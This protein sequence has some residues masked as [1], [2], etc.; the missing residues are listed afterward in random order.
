MI[1]IKTIHKDNH[2]GQHDYAMIAELDGDFAGQLDYSMY[3]AR[4]AVQGINVLQSKRRQGVGTALLVA[5]QEAYPDQAILF[6]MTTT[7]GNA[8]LDSLEWRVEVNQVVAD[9]AEEIATLTQ[10]LRGYES[11]AEEILEMPPS[12]R[13]AAL[14]DMADWNEITDRVEELEHVMN[15]RPAQ[16]RYIVSPEKPTLVLGM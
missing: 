12:E 10:K 3:Q 14:Q 9:A 4:V 11:R 15:T 7:D 16:F 5:L 6:G 13:G 1:E 8:L 2:W